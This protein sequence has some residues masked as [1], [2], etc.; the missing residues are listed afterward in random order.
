M[1]ALL[2]ITNHNVLAGQTVSLLSQFDYFLLVLLSLERWWNLAINAIVKTLLLWVCGTS[3]PCSYFRN[4]INTREREVRKILCLIISNI[5]KLK[6]VHWHILFHGVHS[7]PFPYWVGLN[8]FRTFESNC[9]TSM[10]NFI[11]ATTT[12]ICN[13]GGSSPT[14]VVTF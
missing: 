12:K 10:C 5:M 14:H 6:I 13:E 3:N 8:N 7:F 11:L 2:G 9:D 1:L 4:F